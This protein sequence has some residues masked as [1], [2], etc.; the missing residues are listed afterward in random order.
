MLLRAVTF[1]FWG[2]LVDAGGKGAKHLRIEAL[3]HFLPR[4]AYQDLNVAYDRAWE[5]FR[6]ELD[7]GLGLGAS[8]MVNMTLDHLGVALPPPD[9]RSVI[10]Q[11]EEALLKEP[12]LF[13]PGALDVLR[14][15]RRQGLWTALVSDTGITPGRVLRQFLLR[16]DALRLFD[17]LTFSNELG[18]SKACPQT[19]RQTL[20]ALGVKPEEAV[21]IGDLPWSDIRGAK[22]AGLYAVLLLENSHREEGIAQADLA[23]ERLAYLPDAVHHW[24]EAL[25]QGGVW[26]P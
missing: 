18:V 20:A 21:H 1:D 23:L 12:P 3:A 6:E 16:H 14:T 10:R 11:W 8:T 15:L 4:L 9:L 22:S 25:H 7:R 26:R 2:T 17:W 24:E 5:R 13:L 19:F